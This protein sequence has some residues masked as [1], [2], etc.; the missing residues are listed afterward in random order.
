MAIVVG[1]LFYTIV[2]AAVGFVAPWHELTGEKFMTAVAFERAMGSRWI[3]SIILAAALLSLVQML[4]RKFRGASRV[5]V[6][7]GTPRSARC[8]RG[9]V[10]P[11]ESDAVDGRARVGVAT[12]PCMFLGDAILVPVSEVGSVAAASGMARRLRRVLRMAPT[13]ARAPDRRGGSAGRAA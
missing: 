2:I 11:R 7:D 9:Q 6:C 10:H 13:R 1:I 8:P 5:V 3:V 12:A 4:Q